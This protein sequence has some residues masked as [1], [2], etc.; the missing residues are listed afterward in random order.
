MRASRLL[1]LVAGLLAACASSSRAPAPAVAPATVQRTADAD[2]PAAPGRLPRPP[3][4]YLRQGTFDL[5]QILPAAPQSGDARDE[6]DRRIFRETRALQGS[7]RWV[8]AADD[9]NL[10][11]DAMLRH[12]ACSLGVSITRDQAPRL[13]LAL[14]RATGDAAA[15]MLKAKDVYRRQR[16]YHVDDGAICRPRAEL[17]DSFDYP[18]GH[19]TAGWM[20]GLILAEVDPDHATRILARGRAIGDSR[21]ACGVHNASAVEGGRF[22]APTVFAASSSEPEFRADLAAGREELARLRAS[23]A[24]APD[25]ASCEAERTLVDQPLIQ[26]R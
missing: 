10:G 22:T 3:A 14:Q 11:P 8:M 21:I 4:G 26:R 19:S 17:G 5:L 23:G 16:P 18:S 9:A 15:S 24:P 2:L 1:P 12:F 13:V 6:A 7:P 25:A 20:W